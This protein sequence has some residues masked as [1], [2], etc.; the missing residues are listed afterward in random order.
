MGIAP[1][2]EVRGAEI[3]ALFGLESALTLVEKARLAESVVEEGKAKVKHLF[4]APALLHSR[5]ETLQSLIFRQMVSLLVAR[6]P[7]P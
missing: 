6:F 7:V 1:G 4:P 3:G 5:R 2:N